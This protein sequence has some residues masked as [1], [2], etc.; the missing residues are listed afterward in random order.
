MKFGGLPVRY[1]T[2]LFM[3]VIR[4]NNAYDECMCFISY[5]TQVKRASLSFL[6]ISQTPLH[7]V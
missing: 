4:M 1:Y 3:I 5:Q 2:L 6:S 7:I